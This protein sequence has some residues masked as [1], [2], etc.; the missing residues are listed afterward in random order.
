MSRWTTT[1]GIVVD[2]RT[3]GVIAARSRTRV[4]T[5]LVDASSGLGTLGTD[6][7]F[8]FASRWCTVIIWKAR[9]SGETLRRDETSAIGTTWR[10]IAWIAGNDYQWWCW[11][12]VRITVNEGGSSV[13]RWTETYRDV[14]Y[15]FT[16]SAYTADAS[17]R[18]YAFAVDASFVER[19]VGVYYTLGSASD[20]GVAE[21]AFFANA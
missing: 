15:G 8:R 16:L 3:D 13:L 12:F 9:A 2:H 17:T 5:F 1:D 14:I 19:T 10:R 7:T 4:S 21:E 18:V 6:D 11:W 20:P